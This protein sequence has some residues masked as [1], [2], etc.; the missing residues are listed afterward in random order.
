M[1]A[2]LS[3]SLIRHFPGSPAQPRNELS[4][5]AARGE[6]LAFQVAFRTKPSEH[7]IAVKAT[8]SAPDGL[9]MQVRRVGF[10]PVPQFNTDT[11]AEELDGV[12]YIPGYVPDPLFPEAEIIA[13]G[14]ETNAFWITVTV[15]KDT[16]PGSYPI[17]VTL[18]SQEEKTALT[19]EIVIH[20]AR[21]VARRDFALLHLLHA[22]ALCDWYQVELT[23]DGFWRIFESY[24]ANCVAHGQDTVYVPLFTPPLDGVKRPTQLL[25]VHCRN[26]RYQFDWTLVR[27]WVETC[28]RHA[29]T[30]FEWTHFFTQWGVRNAL[31]VYQGRG[32]TARLL[33]PAETEALAPVYRDFL[34]QFLPRLHRFLQ[35]EKLL[36]CSL[37][38]LSDEP[39]TEHYEAYR[40]AREM[41]REF[42]PWMRI[43]E[44]L[45]DLNFAR[46]GL[47]E[48]TVPITRTV[49]DFVR[50]GFNPWVYYCCE[51][52]GYFLN[53]LLDT[54]LIKVRMSGWLFYRTRVRGFLHWA[55][56]YWY[57]NQT[58]RLIDPFTVSDGLSWPNWAHGDPFVVYPGPEGPLDSLRWEVFAESMQDYA[59]LQA[60]QVSPEDSLLAQIQ[61]YANFPRDE[62]WLSTRRREILRRVSARQR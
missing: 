17:T 15:S 1:Q 22:D 36:D 61:D 31:R 45:S 56:N 6:K 32:E 20:P 62:V 41:L 4:L 9:T 53:R 18:S 16:V 13:D 58:T 54:P 10:V 27:R 37:F 23:Q 35:A 44:A 26:G 28:R 19:A 30:G 47:V 43:G 42:A 51:P 39:H 50:E 3:S 11:P 55:M 21:A 8:A 52:R 24:L 48:V 60:A 46:S 59:L 5:E 40:A 49:M 33:W 38:H 25:G 12:G 7:A 29:I 57:Q 2:W 34:T 14:N